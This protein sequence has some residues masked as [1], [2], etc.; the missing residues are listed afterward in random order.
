MGMVGWLFPSFVLSL[1]NSTN[2]EDLVCARYYVMGWKYIDKQYRY[3]IS[4]LNF[5]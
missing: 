1:T 4:V 2:V 3:T 5:S